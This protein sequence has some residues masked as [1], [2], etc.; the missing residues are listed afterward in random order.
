[1]ADSVA[2]DSAVTAFQSNQ[3]PKSHYSLQQE[4]MLPLPLQIISSLD[5]YCV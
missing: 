2:L 5:L 3:F 4:V 1:M